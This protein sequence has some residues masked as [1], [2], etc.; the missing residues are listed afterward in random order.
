MHINQGDRAMTKEIFVTTLILG[1]VAG[2]SATFGVTTD[3]MQAIVFSFPMM[4]ATAITF[5]I[6]LAFWQLEEYSK[7]KHLR[8]LEDFK[9]FG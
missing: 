9:H 7:R 6:G 3:S 1:F 4:V 2:A 5:A 8:Y